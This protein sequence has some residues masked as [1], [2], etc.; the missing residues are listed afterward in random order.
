MLDINHLYG[1]RIQATEGGYHNIY[2]SGGLSEEAEGKYAG[3]MFA[4]FFRRGIYRTYWYELVDEGQPGPEGAFGLLRNN[5][6]EKSA[7]RAVKNLIAILNDRGPDFKPDSLNYIFDGSVNNM[8]EILF[9]KRNGDFYLMIWLEVA[10]WDPQTTTDLYPPPQEV[11]LTLLN[12]HNISSGTLYAFNNSADVNTFTLP[13][14]NNQVTLNV[15]D[16]I[17]IIKLSNHTN[18]ISVDVYQKT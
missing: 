15:T 14:N 11:L 16:K 6:S 18:S 13:I 3:R 9:Q 2:Q 17:S 1:K 7:F 4:E 8:R 5:V 12:N 10:S